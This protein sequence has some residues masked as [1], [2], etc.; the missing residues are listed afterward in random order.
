MIRVVVVSGV[1][2]AGEYLP[3]LLGRSDVEVVGLTEPP[4]GPDWADEVTRALAEHHDLPYVPWPDLPDADV[5]VVTSEPTR[6]AALAAECC[7]RGLDVIVDKPVATRTADAEMLRDVARQTGRHVTV[8]SR[9]G[10]PAMQRARRAVDSGQ[11]GMPRH[12]DFELLSAS[13]LFAQTVERPELILDPRWSGGGEI[14][15]FFGYAVDAVRY[16]TGLEIVDLYCEAAPLTSPMHIEAGV[17]DLA[18]VSMRLTNGGTASATVGRLPWVPAP[19]WASVSVRL[20]GSHGHL[21][22]DDSRPAVRRWRDATQESLPLVTSPAV[23]TFGW[24][25]DNL[26]AARA[27]GAPAYGLDDA[28]AATRATE[29]AVRS[30]AEHEVVTLVE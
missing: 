29:G 28:L 21:Q 25:L 11:V 9:C 14:V 5:A 15:N 24:T 12:V 27:G 19:G 4:D 17:E 16:L 1:R 10:T 23:E 13:A 18:V 3:V 8:M 22:I 30:A 7:R 6:H 20:L 2:H 26:F